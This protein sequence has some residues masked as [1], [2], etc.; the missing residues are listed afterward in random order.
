MRFSPLLL[1]ALLLCAAA[2]AAGEIPGVI[3]VHSTFSSGERSIGEMARECRDLGL[4]FLILSDHDIVRVEY[5]LWPLPRWLGAAR[6]QK[7]VLTA[8][9]DAWLAE[10]RRAREQ[11]G[12]LVV[13][14]VQSTP[15]Y[16]WTGWPF[17][18]AFTVHGLRR[19]IL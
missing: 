15:F 17:T 2:A 3:H 9:P 11:T 6:S 18:D 12:V 8:D 16:Y 7:A 1:S 5:G 10:I 14:G 13:P 19:E 4:G